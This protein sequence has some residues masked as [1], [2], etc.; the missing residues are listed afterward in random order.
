M[1]CSADLTCPAGLTGGRPTRIAGS[2]RA[3]PRPRG[4]FRGGRPVVIEPETAGRRLVSWRAAARAAVSGRPVILDPVGR[5]AVVVEAIAA[6][7]VVF[8][9]VGFRAVVVEPVPGRTVVLRPVRGLARLCLACRRLACR[10][11]AR[12]GLDPPGG[13]LAASGRLRGARPVGAE[14][15]LRAGEPGLPAGAVSA[16]R[17]LLACRTG[18]AVLAVVC[19]GFSRSYRRGTNGASAPR[20]EF[21]PIKAKPKAAAALRHTRR[22][23]WRQPGAYCP[24]SRPGRDGSG[25]GPLRAAICR[26]PRCSRRQFSTR[27]GT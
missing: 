11:L 7:P 18:C 15:R 8:D 14:R 22:K 10:R 20:P 27:L 12:R 4:G 13:R 24:G 6:G 2:V 3:V 16:A 5:R 19:Q 25:D 26:A 23:G 17:I 9:P 21:R 1:A